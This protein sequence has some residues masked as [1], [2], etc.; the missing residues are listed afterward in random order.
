LVALAGS[1]WSI[2]GTEYQ[3]RK[4]GEKS[5]VRVNE[6]A[7]R[8]GMR[9]FG[10]VKSQAVGLMKQIK[11]YPLAKVLAPPPMEFMNGSG[12]DIDTVFPDDFRYFAREFVLVGRR[13][14]HAQPLAIA[15][16]AAI[17]RREQLH[18]TPGQRGW[19]D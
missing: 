2:S 4:E 14:R 7:W 11:V 1:L 8:E 6:T 16:R 19:L 5:W 12:H 3:A 13:V 17:P 18:Q 9:A 15:K 10:S